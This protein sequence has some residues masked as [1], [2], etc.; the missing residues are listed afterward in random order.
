M[1]LCSSS[2]GS[3]WAIMLF[4]HFAIDFLNLLQLLLVLKHLKVFEIT[5]KLA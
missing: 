1:D 3:S 2:S 4:L 5:K